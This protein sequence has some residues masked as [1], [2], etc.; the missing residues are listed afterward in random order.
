MSKTATFILWTNERLPEGIVMVHPCQHTQYAGVPTFPEGPRGPMVID[1]AIELNFPVPRA[2]LA[3]Y[4]TWYLIAAVKCAE[5]VDYFK[6]SDDGMTVWVTY[7]SNPEFKEKSE[8]QPLA[9][10][11]G[12]N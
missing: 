12:Q 7:Q 5:S 6:I 3:T 10:V 11:A 2:E 8:I 9:L 1:Q 4:L